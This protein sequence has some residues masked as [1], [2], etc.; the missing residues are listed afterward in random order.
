MVIKKLPYI[1]DYDD[2]I[3]HKYDQNSNPIIRFM[4]KNK[5]AQ[6]MKNADAVIVGNDYLRS[7]AQKHNSNILQLPTVVLLDNY[8]EAI[9]NYKTKNNN[10]FVIGWIGSKSTSLYLLELLPVIERFVS[11]YD[12]KC[13][14]IGFDNSLISKKIQKK[15]NITIIP[16]NEETEIKD[17]LKF[18]VGIMPLKNNA[19][20]KGKCGFKLIQY[21]SCKKPVIAS[22]VGINK[23]IVEHGKNGF[24][25]DLEAEWYAAFKQLLKDKELRNTMG[26]NNWKKIQ[27]DYNH[28][29]NCEKYLKLIK[30]IV[31]KNA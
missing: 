18:D 30:Q 28:Q 27:K 2:A 3:F 26:E 15:C 24:L 21:M 14:F 13:H 29:N 4:L 6:V 12:A 31:N 17:L 10:T 1:V 7:Y 19:W 11:H 8:I 22:P 16:W 25:A 20:S 5:I 9:S 23:T